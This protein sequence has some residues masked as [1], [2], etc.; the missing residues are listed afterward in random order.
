MSPLEA[1]VNFTQNDR[2]GTIS[3]NIVTLC[4]GQ[5]NA[6]LFGCSDG[7]WNKISNYLALS[8]LTFRMAEPIALFVSLGQ[9]FSPVTSNVWT[10][11]WS[12]KCRL[13]TKLNAQIETNLRDDFLSLI[14]S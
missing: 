12:I 9:K 14:S 6:C 10:H 1:E 7:W 5:Q 8:L 4:L 11:A 2:I 13:I 3:K